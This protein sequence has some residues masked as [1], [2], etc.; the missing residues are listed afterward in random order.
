MD[1]PRWDDDA[2]AWR[3]Y[4]GR[5]R[6][7]LGEAYR[8]A[9]DAD[10]RASSA[11]RRAAAAEEHAAEAA[12]RMESALALSREVTRRAARARAQLNELERLLN[13]GDVRAAAALLSNRRGWIDRATRRGEYGRRP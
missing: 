11:E 5:I 2:V 4:A 10:Q 12:E 13:D 6:E 9:S 8:R 3:R 7:R 1:Q